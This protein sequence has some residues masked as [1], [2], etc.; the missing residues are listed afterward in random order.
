[1]RQ[2]FYHENRLCKKILPFFFKEKII[3][4]PSMKRQSMTGRFRSRTFEGKLPNMTETGR[5]RN[6]I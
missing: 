6:R 3:Y 2:Q 1:M 4:W 5:F